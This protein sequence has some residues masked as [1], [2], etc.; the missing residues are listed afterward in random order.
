[1]RSFATLLASF[2]ALA[3]IP[4]AQATTLERLSLSDLIAKST[5]IV[6]ARVTGSNCA[7]VGADVYTYYQLQVSEVLKAGGSPAQSLQ[8]AVPGGAAMGV[9]QLVPGAP[10]V[11]IGGD[12]VLF[13]W[14]SRS[15]LTQVIGL[16]QGLFRMTQD[17]AGNAILVRPVSEAPMVDKNGA[18][19]IDHAMTFR[20][21]DVRAQILK[22]GN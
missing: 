13:L 17:S 3:S 12:Y 4:A 1:M 9:R 14:T 8:M 19:V 15:G 11:T 2:G 7:M 22:A 10:K 18:A 6:H 21:S 16:S 5:S 20:W